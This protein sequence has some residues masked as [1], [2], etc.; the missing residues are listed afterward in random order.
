MTKFLRRLFC[1]HHWGNSNRLTKKH[2]TAY[3]RC[4]KCGAT[5]KA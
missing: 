1:D 4:R 2:R 3:D 5:R